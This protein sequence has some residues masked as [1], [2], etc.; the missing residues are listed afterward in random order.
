MT[1]P[2]DPRLGTVIDI[3]TIKAAVNA[4]TIPTG[5]VSLEPTYVSILA[6][7]AGIDEAEVQARL[8]N[9]DDG[10]YQA[11]AHV[12]GL[13]FEKMNPIAPDELKRMAAAR[14]AAAEA[15]AAAV[16]KEKATT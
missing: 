14:S 10:L 7:A 5:G 12:K 11:R 6:K 13:V 9:G 4:A 8:S 16:G 15:R 1:S 3:D 2:A